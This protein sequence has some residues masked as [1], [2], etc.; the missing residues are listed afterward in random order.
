[1]EG[2]NGLYPDEMRLERFGRV[3]TIDL[4]VDFLRPGVGNWFVTTAYTLRTGNRVAVTRIELHK[5]QG[6]LIVVG[7]SSY[8]VA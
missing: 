5:D 1:M 3:S 8:I 6:D 2:T 7:T 4:R